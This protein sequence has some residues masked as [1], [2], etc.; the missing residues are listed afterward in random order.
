MFF[1]TSKTFVNGNF[2]NNVK[3]TKLLYNNNSKIN[4]ICKNAS[5]I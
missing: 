5:Y 4:T 1:F 3:A 2:Q